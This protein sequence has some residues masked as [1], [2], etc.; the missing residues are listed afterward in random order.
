MLATPAARG[1]V[2]KVSVQKVDAYDKIALRYSSFNQ[3]NCTVAGTNTRAI[4]V[5]DTPVHVR[6]LVLRKPN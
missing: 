1:R 5:T 6:I 2:D 4:D 3:N